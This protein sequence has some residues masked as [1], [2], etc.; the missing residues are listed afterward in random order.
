M[1]FHYEKLE[2]TSLARNFIKKIYFITLRFP[3]EE[4]YGLTNQ[5]RR[6]AISIALNIAEGSIRKSKKEFHQF[7]R[8]AIGSL[9]EVDCVLKLSIDLGFLD[10]KEYKE[11]E[12]Q[13]R[14]LYFKLIGLSK[15]LSQ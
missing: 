9:T 2:V 1:Q 5:I 10:E 12:P 4:M 14:E 15:Y 7:I 6:A 11:L 8:I 13:L 3:K